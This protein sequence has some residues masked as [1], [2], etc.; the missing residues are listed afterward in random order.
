M[1]RVRIKCRGVQ[2]SGCL[3]CLPGWTDTEVWVVH[4]D[5]TEAPLTNVREI[6]WR[7]VE[8]TEVPIAV[9]HVYGPE[10]DVEAVAEIRDVSLVPIAEP[11]AERRPTRCYDC[12]RP[13]SS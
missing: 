4:D 8:G 13:V 7:A 10:L 6:E 11:V 1:T 12:G 2:I 5:G 3:A 9:L